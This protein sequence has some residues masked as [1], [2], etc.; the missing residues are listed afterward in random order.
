MFGHYRVLVSYGSL[1]AGQVYRGLTSDPRVF[2]MVNAGYL[3]LETLELPESTEPPVRRGRP[4]RKEVA[5]VPG[6]AGPGEGETV[7]DSGG[8]E[9]GPVGS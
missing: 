5:D 6:E 2:M 9:G 3:R 7:G 1:R 4:K 8:D